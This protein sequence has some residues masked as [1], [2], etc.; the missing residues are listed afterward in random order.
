VYAFELGSRYSYLLLPKPWIST[1]S[2]RFAASPE[3]SVTVVSRGTPSQV[4]TEPEHWYTPCDEPQL[5]RPSGDAESAAPAAAANSPKAAQHPAIYARFR[6]TRTPRG[7]VW[8]H[9]A[10]ER[11]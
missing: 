7:I 1:T 4:A 5:V 2:G 6:G 9:G 11:R 3:G 10:A 8:E